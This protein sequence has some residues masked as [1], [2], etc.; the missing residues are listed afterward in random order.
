LL[1]LSACNPKKMSIDKTEWAGLK[2][3]RPSGLGGSTPPP[4]TSKSPQ[5]ESQVLEIDRGTRHSYRVR[6]S[7][8]SALTVLSDGVRLVTNSVASDLE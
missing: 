5:S 1:C 6:E 8:K 7:R 4:G 2:I 3:R